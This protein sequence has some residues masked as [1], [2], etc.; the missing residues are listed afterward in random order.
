MRIPFPQPPAKSRDLDHTP[1]YAVSPKKKKDIL[2]KLSKKV[3]E[4]KGKE[5]PTG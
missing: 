4:K 2:E 5:T 1:Y 3:V